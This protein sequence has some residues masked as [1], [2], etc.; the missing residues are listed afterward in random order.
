VLAE[1]LGLDPSH[2]LADLERRL[3]N[4]EV[5]V[6]EPLPSRVDVP[7]QLPPD[8]PHLVGRSRLIDRVKHRFN[9]GSLARVAVLYGGAGAGKTAL[10]V[11]LAHQLSAEHE[12]GALFVSLRG[13]SGRPV[14]PEELLARMLRALGVPPSDLPAGVEERSGL[15]RTLTSSR[16]ILVV[17]DDAAGEPQVRPLLTPAK[18]TT[19]LV[20]SRRPLL[21]LEA[22]SRDSVELLDDRA[23]R[24]LLAGRAPSSDSD[25]AAM[26]TVLD[27][28]GGLPLALRIIGARLAAGDDETLEDV[29]AMLSDRASRLDWLVAGD[30]AVRASLEVAYCDCEPQLRSVF[31][32]LGILTSDTFGVWA[33]SA[34]C[35]VSEGTALR[36]LGRLREIGLVTASGTGVGGR[37]FRMHDLV[38]S[39]A[40]EK[41]VRLTPHER[42]SAI[43][44]L[45]GVSL[46]LTGFAD[47]ELRK[48]TPNWGVDARVTTSASL[49]EAVRRA[50]LEW[51][52]QETD[53]LTDLVLECSGVH[54]EAAG[55]LGL[56]LAHYLA[57]RDPG[58]DLTDLFSTCLTALK[59]TGR[60]ILETR[61]RQERFMSHVARGLEPEELVEDAGRLLAS[62]RCTGDERLTVN[63]LR[64]VGI[65]N[66]HNGAMATAQA[67]YAEALA[68]AEKL[69][70]ATADIVNGVRS[71]LA[72]V[73]NVTGRAVEAL[74]VIRPVLRAADTSRT[75]AM[76]LDRFAQIAMDAGA[77]DEAH[78]AL[79]EIESIMSEV[80]DEVGRAYVSVCKARHAVLS[81]RGRDAE[82]LLA[83]AQETLERIGFRR[84]VCRVYQVRAELALGDGDEEAAGKYI[85]LAVAHAP[86]RLGEMRAR[87]ILEL[88]SR[89]G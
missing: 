80:P 15:W 74:E 43:T 73:L 49:E 10:A 67:A 85:D 82:V 47:A 76:H 66:S 63:S 9:D 21:G 70:P 71:Q 2:E 89:R 31:D 35:G 34:V 45:I 84:G 59:E 53:L 7:R 4:G 6:S 39:F 79:S 20:T 46:R 55:W 25:S 69:V 50:A 51:I 1:E 36:Y 33:V 22:A 87:Q 68:I 26:K 18:R 52:D 29:A 32:R 48:G 75:R 12:D 11:R 61:L 88:E 86:D 42:G 44:D 14:P 65:A 16:A 8:L 77:L 5:P 83:G 60:P 41:W 57:M 64:A 72:E 56:R 28:C 17:L 27:A 30:L 40:E 78:A 62:A 13:G 37:R 81:G 24:A 54:P 23:S 3:L 19:V 58:R 38:R